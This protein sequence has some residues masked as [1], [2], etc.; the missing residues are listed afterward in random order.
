M[1]RRPSPKK[2]KRTW[3]DVPDTRH[4]SYLSWP[5]PESLHPSAA[6]IEAAADGDRHARAIATAYR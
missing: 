3:R 5:Q 2:P 4:R 1:S 6:T